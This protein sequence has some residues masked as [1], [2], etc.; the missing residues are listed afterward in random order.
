MDNTKFSHPV[1][2]LHTHTNF[3]DGTLSPRELVELAAS[4]GISAIALTDHNTIEG[5][6]H[7]LAEAGRGVEL[8]PGIEFST[9]W[10]EEELHIIALGITEE[11]YPTVNALV[12]DM[13]A[14]KK[15]A[16]DDLIAA[17]IAA[18]YKI[19]PERIA[20]GF[21]GQINRAHIAKELIRCGYVKDRAEAFEHLLA[22]DGGYYREAERISSLDTIKAI[23][24]MGAV[25]VLAHPLFNISADKLREFLAEACPLGLDA[26]EVLYSEY[27]EEEIRLSFEIADSF[28]LLPS[29]GSDFH[30]ENKK[31]ISLVRGK[32]N[33]DIPYSV[34]E[35][36]AERLHENKRRKYQ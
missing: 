34:W 13:K 1:C 12:E 11:D 2:D 6:P 32:G 14:R 27:S 31:D 8:I 18:G 5:V 26:I 23:H 36:L 16:T 30:G 35:R 22:K 21:K 17:L 28:G 29:G 24:K 25:S 33:L 10:G 7:L 4:L 15:K 3:S 20:D 9:S 19:S